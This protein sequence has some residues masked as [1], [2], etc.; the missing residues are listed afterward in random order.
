M[1]EL[2]FE[3]DVPASLNGQPSGIEWEPGWIV[4][5]GDHAKARYAVRTIG[6]ATDL[7]LPWLNGDV[8]AGGMR[9]SY[10]VLEKVD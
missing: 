3:D 10:Y 4:F 7:F 6:G 5:R 8:I 2:Q 1:R 9:P